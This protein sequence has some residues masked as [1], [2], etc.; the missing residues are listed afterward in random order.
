MQDFY[1]YILKCSDGSYYT[2]HTDNIE[3]R[4]QEHETGRYEG[5]TATRLPVQVVFIEV[6]ASRGDALEAEMQIKQW[7][8]KK[9]EVLIEYGWRGMKSFA[10]RYK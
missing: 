5:Y 4:V 8:R 10:K 3:L 2:G 9:K 7:S 1:I 6:M